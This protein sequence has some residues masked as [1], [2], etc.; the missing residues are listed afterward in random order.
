MVAVVRGED[1]NRS[2]LVEVIRRLG[3]LIDAVPVIGMT[4]TIAVAPAHLVDTR[5][6][7]LALV[8]LRECISVLEVESGRLR[9]V[10]VR[11]REPRV[12]CMS[13]KSFVHTALLEGQVIEVIELL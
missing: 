1:G 13:I 9:I 8:H 11:R 12:A 5:R 6:R 4:A 2:R 3:V 10:V 7:L